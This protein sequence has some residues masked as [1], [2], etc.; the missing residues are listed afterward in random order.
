MAKAG[1]GGVS[2]LSQNTVKMTQNIKMSQGS[3][4]A[5]ES[6]GPL[7]QIKMS[8]PGGSGNRPTIRWPADSKPDASDKEKL[9]IITVPTSKMAA[10]AKSPAEAVMSMASLLDHQSQ[11]LSTPSP[12]RPSSVSPTK[13]QS[14]QPGT[15]RP[16]S[17]PSQSKSPVKFSPATSKPGPHS[18]IQSL[19]DRQDVAQILASLSGFVPDSGDPKQQQAVKSHPT[20]VIQQ[21][22][23]QI[24]DQ[25]D[26]GGA[27]AESKESP[28][29][30][31]VVAHKSKPGGRGGLVISVAETKTAV[32]TSSSP[33]T[34]S[35]SS[36]SISSTLSSNK[37]SMSSTLSSLLTAPASSAASRP[38]MVT[39][40]CSRSLQ[41]TAVKPSGGNPSGGKGEVV[42]AA[43]GSQGDA[44]KETSGDVL[45]A[46][47]SPVETLVVRERQRKQVHCPSPSVMEEVKEEEESHSDE[48]YQPKYI[49]AGL[50]KKAK[51]LP[52][53]Q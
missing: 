37:S 9:Y 38:G 46:T 34:P 47:Q 23:L 51:P 19:A 3:V 10:D 4:A 50:K 18:P 7:V 29:G 13:Q 15:S 20:R 39:A 5:K 21:T 26:K 44:S 48:E 25:S 45:K 8:H 12:A 11:R 32:G 31:L 22:G 14:D 33:V 40:S 49:K 2:H 16:A 17:S 53:K 6:G 52:P 41:I 43:G 36:L 27:F 1:Q 28:E 42:S 24:K 35:A 30:L